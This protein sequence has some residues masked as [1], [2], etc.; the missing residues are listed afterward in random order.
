MKTFFLLFGLFLAATAPSSSQ[1]TTKGWWAL[2]NNNDTVAIEAFTKAIAD[3]SKDLRAYLGLMYAY[4]LRVDDRRSWQALKGALQVAENPHPYLYASI[5]QRRFSMNLFDRN[6]G[7]Y[8]VLKNVVSDP[9]PTGTLAAMACEQLG[10]IEERRGDPAAARKW[11]DRIGAIMAWRVIGPF[12]NVSASGHDKAFA[13]EKEDV[14]TATY[15]GESGRKVWWFTPPRHRTDKWIDFAN[16]FPSV[17]GVFYATTYVRSEKAQRV[18]LRLGT[19]GAYKLF[20]NNAVVSENVEESNNDLDTYVTEVELQQGWNRILVKCDNS[21]LNRCNF[22]LRI[23]DAKGV[24]VPGLEYSAEKQDIKPGDAKPVMLPNPFTAYFRQKIEED[25]NALENHLLLI[26]ALLR[27]EQVVEAR[28]ALKKALKLSP[29]CIST[30]ML[31]IDADN[32]GR[33]YD[34]IVST[35]EHIVTLR[36]D[37]PTSIMYAFQK[38][39][40]AE[41]FDEAEAMLPRIEAALPNST[42]YFDAAVQVARKRDRPQQV[43]ELLARAYATYPNNLTYASAAILT[44]LRATGSFEEAL[45]IVDQH[46]AL[47][48]TESALFIK[49][50]LLSESGRYEEADKIYDQLFELQPCAPGYHSRM[51][52]DY[53][54]RKDLRKALASVEEAL[55]DAPSVSNLWQ[56]A[57]TYRRSLGDTSGARDA[58][59]KA[60]DTDPNNFDAR[61]A[62]REMSGKPSPFTYMPKLNVDSLISKS[63]TAKEYPNDDAIVLANDQRRVVYQGSRC[64]VEYELLIRVLTTNGIDRFKEM[65]LPGG[66][67]GGYYVEK[68]VVR[69]P[70]G[71]EFPADVSGSYAVFKGLEPGDFIYAKAKSRESGSGRLSAYFN[72]DYLFNDDIPYLHARYALM[73]PKNTVFNYRLSNAEIDMRSSETPYGDLF[74]WEARDL[75]AIKYEE[76]MPRLDAVGKYLQI[77]SI[78]RWGEIVD[79]YYDIARTKTRSTDEIKEVV[80]SLLPPSETYTPMDVISSV[81]RYITNDIRYSAVPFRQS[82]IVPQKASDVLITRIGDCKDVATLCIAMLAERKIPAYHVLVQTNTDGVTRELL[83]SIPFDHAIVLVELE[84]G[85][86]FLDLTADNVPVGSLP[87]ADMDAFSLV[88]RPGYLIP[89]RIKR[90]LFTPNNVYVDTRIAIKEDLSA[91]IEQTLRHTGARTQFYRGAWKELGK[92]D[93]E[94]SLI[95]GL[96]SDLPEVKLQDVKMEGLDTLTSDFTLTLV[97]DVPNYVMEAANLQIVRIPWYDPYEPEAG[98]GYDK[99]VY[100]F[101]FTNTIDTIHENISINVPAGYDALGIKEKETMENDAAIVTRSYKQDKGTLSVSRNAVYRRNVIYPHEYQEYRTFYNNVV[102]ADRQSVLFAPKGTVVKAPNVKPTKRSAK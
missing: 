16:F 25:P 94:R 37:L 63:P 89:S 52:N 32:R 86:V 18:Q 59:Q 5:L 6:S 90:T 67:H 99:R 91:T 12:H 78:P 60:L 13:P 24:I 55:K 4:D 45:K 73:T 85:P 48:Y 102:R 40:N 22:L 88:I 71:R 61:E 82:G 21:E 35:T 74:I 33:R 84:A 64:E 100:P 41:R 72:D 57:G 93:L 96:S 79:W 3:D 46:L 66:G 8:E 29:D 68:A 47:S 97:Y 76:G 19:S 65:S 69:K 10:A 26:E 38:E 50:G 77:S 87:F 23:T 2:T 9:D 62:L 7:V 11:Y 42:D 81:Y 49:A 1:S 83:P 92:E 70:N 36:P 44:K 28:R 75:A 39:M 80:D 31:S 58:F 17:Y 43:D 101:E 15:E 30:L 27:N 53:E 56:A 95:E 98:L 34:H 14:P 51:A 20:L 54:A